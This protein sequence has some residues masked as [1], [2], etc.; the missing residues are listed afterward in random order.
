MA[1]SLQ[2]GLCRQGS[3]IEENVKMLKRFILDE[4][5]LATVEYAIAG[6]MVTLGLVLAFTNLSDAVAGQIT[7]IVKL[8]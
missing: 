3:E 4:D 5:G 2:H 7:R 6:S 8:F 1:L